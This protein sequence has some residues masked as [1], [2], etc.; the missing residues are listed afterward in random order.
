MT[1]DSAEEA[2]IPEGL[3]QEMLILREFRLARGTVS[4]SFFGAANRL[5]KASAYPLPWPAYV[6]FSEKNWATDWAIPPLPTKVSSS[7]MTTESALA[8]G[9][10]F[11]SRSHSSFFGA[12][13]AWASRKSS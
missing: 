6:S 10:S 7:E 12:E 1:A 9:I 11:S 13:L 3:A 2:A 8:S 5:V 4:A